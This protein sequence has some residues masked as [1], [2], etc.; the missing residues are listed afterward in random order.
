[1]AEQRGDRWKKIRARFRTT[2]AP[3]EFN[4]VV[5]KKNLRYYRFEDDVVGHEKIESVTRR[6]F[7]L[8]LS[9]RRR[10]VIFQSNIQRCRIYATGINNNCFFLRLTVNYVELFQADSITDRY[11][12]QSYPYN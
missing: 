2:K 4:F 6:N 8:A 5:K 3:S 12:G 11:R 9:L 1:M 7:Y 10:E